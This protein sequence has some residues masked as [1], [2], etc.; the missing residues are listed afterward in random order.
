V[1]ETP[2]KKDAAPARSRARK[3]STD[4][5]VNLLERALQLENERADEEWLHASALKD[6]M[7]RLDPS[8]SEKGLGFRSFSDF[9]KAHPEV[10]EVD[11]ASNVVVVRSVVR[12]A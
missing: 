3:R 6:L 1:R 10:V 8:F 4:P 12:P 5:S 7:K 9:V 2:S 11:E